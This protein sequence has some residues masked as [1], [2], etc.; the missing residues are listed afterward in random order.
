MLLADELGAEPIY[1]VNNGVSHRESTQPGD[2]QPFIV[3]AM[4]ALEFLAGPPNSTWGRERAA[5][6]RDA[7]WQINYL[8]IGN[9]VGQCTWKMA[10]RSRPLF[11]FILAD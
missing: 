2:L 7:P 10:A 11:G 6:G 8:A 9:E 1:V 3:E 5:M 4:D